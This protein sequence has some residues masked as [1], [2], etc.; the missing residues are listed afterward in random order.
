MG[1][2]VSVTCMR[3]Q[4]VHGPL[5]TAWTPQG[6]PR[7]KSAKT[8]MPIKK[9]EK[10]CVAKPTNGIPAL[11]PCNIA[12]LTAFRSLSFAFARPLPA[13]SPMIAQQPFSREKR[14]GTHPSSPAHSPIRTTY[15]HIPVVCPV[16]QYPLSVNSSKR[17][18]PASTSCQ[19]RLASSRRALG[20]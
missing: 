16:P 1:A 19:N 15:R 20:K 7:R 11:R 13:C 5:T 8:A 10:M 3:W 14:A 18:N 6:F 2:T 17:P 12:R 4:S 9:R